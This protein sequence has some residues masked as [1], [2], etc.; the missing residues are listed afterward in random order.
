MKTAM[1]NMFAAM[2]AA[3]VAYES[4]PYK[5][6]KG[7][8]LPKYRSGNPTRWRSVKQDLQTQSQ[9]RHRADKEENKQKVFDK[10]YR[11]TPNLPEFDL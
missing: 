7:Y 9:K 6:Q 11:S 3:Y 2:S 5:L 10:R 1:I 8:S 4:N